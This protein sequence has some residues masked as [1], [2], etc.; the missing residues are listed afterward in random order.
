MK[1]KERLTVTDQSSRLGNI[2]A[3]WNRD[4]ILDQKEDCTD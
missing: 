4:R 2:M 1:N 3:T